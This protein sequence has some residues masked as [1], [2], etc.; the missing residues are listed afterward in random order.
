VNLK[1][2][3]NGTVTFQQQKIFKFDPEKSVGDEGDMVVVP[4]VPMLVSDKFRNFLKIITFI[5]NFNENYFLFV[6][7]CNITK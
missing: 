2:N 5:F 7:E 3:E 6:S 1:F 4:N